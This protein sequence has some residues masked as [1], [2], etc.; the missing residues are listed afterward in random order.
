VQALL[1]VVAQHAIACMSANATAPVVADHFFEAM[2][3][4]DKDFGNTAQARYN[5][6]VERLTAQE[7]R[8]KFQE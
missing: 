7:W 4:Q 3:T 2:N 8:R 5:A 1:P 6:A